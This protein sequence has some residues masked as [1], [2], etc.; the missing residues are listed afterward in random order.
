MSD[1]RITNDVAKSKWRF[2][3]VLPI[4]A[5]IITAVPKI[6]SMEFMVTN[7]E[8]AGMG[9]MTFL[10]GIIE[11]AC[12]IV[13]LVPQSRK[14][15]FLLTTAYIGGIIAA[16]WISPTQNPA[17]GIVLQT[18]LWIGVYFEYPEMFKQHATSSA[19]APRQTREMSTT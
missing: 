13:F 9:H 4:A 10:V 19:P 12:V 5:L 1:L 11:L 8:A 3:W 2:I 18:L 17:P 15:G 6:L 16:E 14:V 7:M